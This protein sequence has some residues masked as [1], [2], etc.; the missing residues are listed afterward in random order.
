MPSLLPPK[1][2]FRY[3]KL[4]LLLIVSIWE[5]RIRMNNKRFQNFNVSR[6]IIDTVAS[7]AD[8]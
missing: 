6:K 3:L 1:S 8:K 5:F 7:V 2:K 4:A